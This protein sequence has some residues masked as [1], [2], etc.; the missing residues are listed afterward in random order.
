MMMATTATT[1]TMPMPT[2]MLTLMIAMMIAMTLMRTGVMMIS[3][4]T[5]LTVMRGLTFK[6]IAPSSP[7]RTNQIT[8]GTMRATCVMTMMITIRFQMKMTS[9]R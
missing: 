4:M 1:M 9:V 7:M 5:T 3:M 6:T 8:I 2:R